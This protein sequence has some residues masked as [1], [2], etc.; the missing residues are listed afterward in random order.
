MTHP[1]AEVARRIAGLAEP[2]A[3]WWYEMTPDGRVWWVPRLPALF[4]AWDAPS[5]EARAAV[6][7]NPQLAGVRVVGVRSHAEARGANI[8]GTTAILVE[9]C[10]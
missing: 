4:H 3:R 2:P 10:E 1:H 9:A 8:G 5:H 6:A 7:S